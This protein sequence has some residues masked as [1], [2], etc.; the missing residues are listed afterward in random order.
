MASSNAAFRLSDPQTW[1][2]WVGIALVILS[3]IILGSSPTWARIAFE[4]GANAEAAGFA[5]FAFGAAVTLPILLALPNRA[6]WL[7][8]RVLVP[9]LGI[10]ALYAGQSTTYL[11]ALDLLPVA[12]AVV[13]LFTFPLF[14]AL[15]SRFTDRV[16]IGA[17]KAV[18]IGLAFIGV[19]LVTQAAPMAVN[20]AGLG[21]A[22]IAAIGT[23]LYLVVGGRVSRTVGSLA[24]S[25][26]SFLGAAAVMG[27]WIGVTG[28]A[29]WPQTWVGWGAFCLLTGTF[30]GGILLFLT[31]LMCMET[32]HATLFA[33]LEPLVAIGFAFLVLGEPIGGLQAVGAAL[34][35]F[36]VAGPTVLDARSEQRRSA[37]NTHR[38]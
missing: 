20:P 17:P 13:A 16:P 6:V 36:A 29:E 25:A 10:G 15:I 18:G 14:V 22:L 2:G 8:P 23:A 28:G 21:F 33:N 11:I 5:R 37:E 19:V 1:P 4:A 34:V 12:I 3:T 38:K 32:V 35:I 24:F 27:G 26:L 9:S 7:T 30:I 31:A